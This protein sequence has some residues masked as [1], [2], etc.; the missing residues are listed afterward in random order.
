MIGGMFGGL[1]GKKKVEEVQEA[2]AEAPEAPAPEPDA[3]K[4]LIIDDDPALLELLTITLQRAMRCE[5]YNAGTG[6]DAIQILS[7]MSVDLVVSDLAMPIVDGWTLFLWLAKNQPNLV[8]RFLLVSGALGSDPTA[9]AIQSIG[10]KV[11]KKPFHGSDFV[12]AC[13]ELLDTPLPPDSAAA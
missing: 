6:Q 9:L 7:S 8:H 5:V 4:I 13:R 2:D 12:D 10:V 11:L 3:P 1:F